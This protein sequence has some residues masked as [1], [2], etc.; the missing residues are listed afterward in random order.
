MVGNVGAALEHLE[1]GLGLCHAYLSRGEENFKHK[2]DGEDNQKKEKASIEYN[3][4]A[5]L[6]FKWLSEGTVDLLTFFVRMDMQVLSLFPKKHH[7]ETRATTQSRCPRQ[8]RIRIPRQIPE[9][10]TH[11]L[12]LLLKYLLQFLSHSA[13]PMKY[14]TEI[15][16]VTREGQ[17]AFLNALQ[18]W[19]SMFLQGEDEEFSWLHGR[20]DR[21]NSPS[22]HT[23]HLFLLYHL[24]TIKVVTALC[25]TELIFSTPTCISCF[26]S[27]VAYSSVILRNRHAGNKDREALDVG[28]RRLYFSSESSVIEALYFT[29]LKCRDGAVRRAALDL[30]KSAGKEGIWDG[31][32]MAKVAEHVMKKEEQLSSHIQSPIISQT[33]N[34]K[35]NSQ[36]IPNHDSL[37]TSSLVVCSEATPSEKGSSMVTSSEG[38]SK[39]RELLEEEALVCKVSMEMD[40]K[41]ENVVVECGWFLQRERRWK[42]E[43]SVLP[44]LGIEV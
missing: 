42:Y 36:L 26:T 25:P 24:T 32:V 8:S 3:C 38:I 16:E 41:G 44:V 34:S 18:N 37:E 13:A 29:A 4:A 2:F 11:S 19:R 30:L 9:Q 21:S 27:I 35:R 28:R 43:T 23:A 15:P 1:G 10:P 17:Q 7:S 5:P 22:V 33:F 14:A 39:E 20:V 31:A 6:D 40:S 12:Y